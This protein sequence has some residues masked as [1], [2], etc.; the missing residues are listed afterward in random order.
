MDG[1]VKE[2]R[3]VILRITMPANLVPNETIPELAARMDSTSMLRVLR[4]LR[5]TGFISNTSSLD[6]ETFDILQRLAS[7]GLADP[8]YEGPTNGLPFIWVSNHNG[9]RVLSYLETS[10]DQQK[11]LKSKVMVNP[12]AG[13]ALSSLS[14]NEQLAV[15]AAAEGLYGHD[16]ASWPRHAVRRL[17]PDKPTYLLRVSPDLRAFIKFES[18]GIE[19]VDIVREKTL[20]LF[21]ERQEAAAAHQ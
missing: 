16:P 20:Q 13:I 11:R 14:E 7:L 2:F 15:L 1:R 4:H 21:L 12:R 3:Q 5:Q 6:K 17:S 18:G 9:E 10:P 19:L 8:G